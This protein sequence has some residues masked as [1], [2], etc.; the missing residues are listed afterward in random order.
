MIWAEGETVE[1]GRADF[2][3]EEGTKGPFCDQSSDSQNQTDL[4]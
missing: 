1:N 2:Q 4:K 3:C